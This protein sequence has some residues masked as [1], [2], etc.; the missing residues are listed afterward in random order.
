MKQSWEKPWQTSLREIDQIYP[1][2]QF[3]FNCEKVAFWCVS[4]KTAPQDTESLNILNSCFS[5][6]P[7]K[8]C[9]H[10][11]EYKKSCS[12]LWGSAYIRARTERD[13]N[14]DDDNDDSSDDGR[15]RKFAKL[16]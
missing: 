9:S 14:D 6:L 7:A 16:L 2:E 11:Y 1:I 12:V 10:V 4:E 5:T 3:S 13:D 15:R 8:S